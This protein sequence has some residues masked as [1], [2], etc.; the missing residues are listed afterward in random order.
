MRLHKDKKRQDN[1]VKKIDLPLP[2]LRSVKA[3]II[4]INLLL[5]LDRIPNKNSSSLD[6]VVVAMYKC[7]EVIFVYF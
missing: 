5:A 7:S 4:S 3:R 1:Y 2:K 6:V